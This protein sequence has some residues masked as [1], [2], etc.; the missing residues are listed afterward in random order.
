MRAITVLLLGATIPPVLQPGLW[1]VAS[2]PGAATLDGRPLTDLP[3]TPPAGPATVCLTPA[4]AAN[5][6][7]WLARDAAKGCDLSRRSLAG[8]EVHL[9]GTCAPQ[10]ADLARGTVRITGRWTPTSYDLRFATENPSEN[11]RMGF[12][13]TLTGRR[14]GPCA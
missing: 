5:P 4:E 1:Q 2:A 13:G 12:T 7:A 14:V 8:G 10:T 6:A 3:Y 9:A 11:G